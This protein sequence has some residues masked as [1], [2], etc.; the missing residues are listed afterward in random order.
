MIK[1]MLTKICNWFRQLNIS[2]MDSSWMQKPEK[3]DSFNQAGKRLN[4]AFQRGFLKGIK[5]L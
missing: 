1:E 3:P 2:D 5:Q 4:K